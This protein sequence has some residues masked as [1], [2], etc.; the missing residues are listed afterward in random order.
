MAKNEKG[1]SLGIFTSLQY[2][3]KTGDSY[4]E[5]SLKREVSHCLYTLVNY[6]IDISFAVGYTHHVGYTDHVGTCQAHPL[7]RCICKILCYLLHSV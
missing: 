5:L 7:Y 1:L 6:A 3:V 4:S 2:V